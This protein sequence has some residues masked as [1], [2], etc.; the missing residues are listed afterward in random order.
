PALVGSIFLDRASA[1]IVR[2]SFTFTP[3]SY[4]DR[5]LDYIHVALDNGLWDGRYWLPHEQRV[6]IRRQTPVLDFPVGGV[7]RGVMSIGEYRFNQ[8]IPDAFF[9]G[10]PVV[11]LP[12]S[13]RREHPFGTGLFDGLDEEGLAGAAAPGQL[14]LE[15][16]RREAIR[17]V[18]RRRLSGLPRLRLHLPGASAAARYDRA[19]GAFAGAGLSYALTPGLF[20]EA[21]GGYATATDRASGSVALNAPVG[22]TTWR[23]GLHARAIRDLGPR[24]GAPR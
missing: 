16:L 19:E 13:M 11:A 4:V 2:M 9:R 23:L 12:E 3:A 22:R 5:R 20:L 21:T 1:A 8:A 15:A 14:D 24:A 17:L 18:G 6:E 7:I 10:A